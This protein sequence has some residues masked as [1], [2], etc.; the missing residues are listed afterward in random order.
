MASS[1]GVAPG[2]LTCTLEGCGPE[3]AFGLEP[4][5]VMPLGLEPSTVMPSFLCSWP[6]PTVGEDRGVLSSRQSERVAQGSQW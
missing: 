2:A 5:T 6:D 1:L 3:V 4:S